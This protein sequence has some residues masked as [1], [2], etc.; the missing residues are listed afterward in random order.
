MSVGSEHVK[1]TQKQKRA[2]VRRFKAFRRCA[3]CGESDPSALDI[4]HVFSEHKNPKLSKTMGSGR[5]LTGGGMWQNMSF[6]EIVDELQRCVVICA[7][8]HRKVT[9][10]ERN[11]GLLDSIEPSK[12]AREAMAV[13][14]IQKE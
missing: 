5:M 4:H 11:W 10:R 3:E 9:A 1:K 12:A 6:A 8:C 2:L 7:N 13:L 14:G